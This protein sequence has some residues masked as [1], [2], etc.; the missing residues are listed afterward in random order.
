MFRSV[1]IIVTL[2]SLSAQSFGQ[3][4]TLIIKWKRIFNINPH[5]RLIFIAIIFFV[6]SNQ[7]D[8]QYTEWTGSGNW[9]NNSNWTNSYIFGQLEWKGNGNISS[10]ND[11][12]LTSQWRLYFDGGSSYFITGFPV[13]LF[14]NGGDNS[15]ILSDASVDQNLNLEVKFMD[16]GL[17]SAW[18]TTRSSGGLNFSNIVVGGNVTELRIASL[19][20]VGDITVN[21]TISASSK[22]III[23]RDESSNLQGN[24]RVNFSSAS[25]YS[26]ST[27]VAAGILTILDENALGLD[28][29][30]TI[31]ESGASLL[32][33]ASSSSTYNEVLIL[34]GVGV[35]GQGALQKM[36]S[37]SDNYF[38]SI[39]LGSDSRINIDNGSTLTFRDANF[40]FGGN[41]LYIGGSQNFSFGPNTTYSNASKTVDDGTI[42]KD[43]TGVFELRP[44]LNLTGN[45]TL[46]EGEIRQTVNDPYPNSGEII[47]RG[48]TYRSSS[49]ADRIVL[50]PT[51]VESDF[52][53]GHS[54]GGSIS[55]ISA[56]NLANGIRNIFMENNNEISGVISNG[57][58]IKS[59]L[60]SLTLSGTAANLLDPN[61]EVNEGLL[62]LNK[63]AGI[64]A[65][66]NLI[67]NTDGTVRTDQDNQWGTGTP[68][69]IQIFGNG[70]LDINNTNQNL[71]LAS[72]SATSSVI[73]GSGTLTINNTATD[74]FQGI[75]SGNGGIVKTN[76]GV[77]ILSGS[78]TYSG[79][80]NVSGGVLQISSAERISNSSDLILNGG[81]FSTG[82]GVGYNETLSALIL[83]ENSTIELGSGSH[84]LHFDASN[85]EIWNS[86][87]TLIVTGWNG[88]EE[89][90]GLEGK[91]YVG[92]D[93]SGLTSVQLANINFDGFGAGAVILNTGEVV[94]RDA[95][96]KL[97]DN[98]N[99][100]DNVNLGVPNG[101]IN[102]WTEVENLN[103]GGANGE[104][105]D[106][107]NSTLRLS[108]CVSSDNDAGNKSAAYDAS[109]IYSTTFEDA[110]GELRW[111]FNMRQSR[112]DPSNFGASGYGVAF[113]IGANESDFGSSTIDGY[114]V[115]LGESGSSDHIRLI[116]FT[117]GIP[118][119]PVPNTILSIQPNSSNLDH[120][121]SIVVTFNPCD[122]SWSLN[123]R[124][125]G[126]SAFSN[127]ISINEPGNSA[128]NNDFI[129]EPL[130]YVGAYFTHSSGCGEEAL[131]D[132]IYIPIEPSQT[133]SYTWTGGSTG[134]YQLSTNWSPQR[135]CKKNNDRLV[136]STNTSIS[137]TNVPNELIGY[138]E[139][140]NNTSLTLVDIDNSTT[141]SL[142]I[143]NSG[144][145]LNVSSGSNLILDV[146]SSATGNGVQFHLLGNTTGVI[147]GSF[148]MT[149]SQTGA[150]R[151][152]LLE[153]ESTGAI[154]VNGDIV[155]EDLT[156][157]PFGSSTAGSVIFNSGSTLEIFDGANPF[158]LASPAS[159]IEFN[160]GSTY[161][162]LDPQ[163]GLSITGRTYANFIFDAG[164]TENITFSGTNTWTVEDLRVLSG[165][166]NASPNGALEIDIS[167]DLE[168]STGASFILNPDLE[169]TIRF[170]GSSLQTIYGDGTLSFGENQ[171]LE[172]DNTTSGKAVSIEK[173]IVMNNDFRIIDGRVEGTGYDLTMNGI[174]HELY[175]ND[176]LLGEFPG[177]YNEISLIIS[178]NTSLKGSAGA[179]DFFDITVNNSK[180][181]FLE[182]SI[183]CINGT[184][185]IQDNA[186]LQINANGF[187]ESVNTNAVY[188][189]YGNNSILVY[190]TGNIYSRNV[191]WFTESGAGF[192]YNVLVM[193]GTTLNPGG[194]YTNE[195]LSLENNLEIEN[196]AFLYMDFG[197]NDMLLPLKIGGDLNL[198]GELSLSD[199]TDG[200][201]E[202]S[203]DWT[204]SG[205][206]NAQGRSV[207]FLG[208]QMQSI[209]SSTNLSFDY[210]E[211]NNS[212]VD[213]IQY[214]DDFSINVNLVFQDGILFGQ[215]T[216][217]VIFESGSNYTGASNSSHI[218]GW[219][220]K[221]GDSDFLF[222]TGGYFNDPNGSPQNYLQEIGISS[223]SGILTF[224]ARYFPETHP[225]LPGSG[226]YN[227]TSQQISGCDYWTLNRSGSPGEA[228]VTLTYGETPCNTVSD[229]N[230]LRIARWNGLAWDYPIF[231]GSDPNTP[232]EVSTISEVSNFSDFA[233]ATEGGFG[234]NVLPI[235]LLNFTAR[236]INNQ[237]VLLEWTTATETNNDFFTLER[238]VDGENFERI[239]RV[240][241]AGNATQILNYSFV[242]DD[243]FSGVSY[244]RLK[245]TD[246]DGSFQYSDLRAVEVFGDEQFD[247]KSVFRSDGGLRL[248]YT[249]DNP[250]LTLE[251]FDMT[252]KRVHSQS[253]ENE[254]N[255]IIYPNI[256]R[257]VYLLRLSNG[258]HM[259][260]EKFF[261]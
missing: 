125:D 80:T 53:V 248:I 5:L 6:I 201:L 257:G 36:D 123:I 91:I 47:F 215:G 116:H 170:N 205:S 52:T 99:R 140:S 45:I 161:R 212:S 39:S 224:D 202:I 204:Q 77:Q 55:F 152:H 62:I 85:T 82:T 245:Q 105:I 141:S 111:Y 228:I 220:R 207:R 46:V 243:P 238:S 84:S 159:V 119:N 69:F 256:A 213:G 193:S 106:L 98:F 227:G 148:I 199:Q 23:G 210:L 200:D 253:L 134:D 100:T 2:L 177:V 61:S 240:D 250:F 56:M 260:S 70:V 122:K 187:V 107:F 226:Y 258:N 42:F 208:N 103:G 216:H 40:D 130:N 3:F 66:D 20:T 247:L 22:P 184:F 93:N 96:Y 147:D 65:T 158:Q 13:E 18:I 172:I 25:L 89:S 236:N 259:A 34:N 112:S 11:L 169:S 19:N 211:I 110:A 223:L 171:I 54:G 74:E 118:S 198:F 221:I 102:A 252:G 4:N 31:V 60:G 95:N 182:R 197:S 87:S 120:Y 167:G 127:P 144:I 166:L 72:S 44:S 76:S 217:K 203:G 26:G 35:S 163:A 168:V 241:G 185:S 58:L 255:S 235:E 149:N 239:G 251:I 10:N 189:I 195:P 191:E 145:G 59:G 92:N 254:A 71:A 88:T 28:S 179:C 38:G 139:V 135:A 51:R 181:L 73:L 114:A 222:P 117:D 157:P 174:D 143:R 113:I 24:T 8:G 32:L 21:G 230:Y 79:S 108:N 104:Y 128:T 242:D 16:N 121:F 90:S 190:N 160:S 146:A 142:S 129:S 138:L 154:Q 17:R 12:N 183:Q 75:I 206:F 162:Y 180:T 48:G 9:S 155:V 249:S 244:Y 233:L 7:V 68:P 192:P 15:W 151:P 175:V 232:N 150:G 237:E 246:F 97:L 124:D 188:P 153:A 64:Q 173:D 234:L 30:P 218:D 67:I 49:T 219:V 27:T 137:V 33:N 57:S 178:E 101:Y 194:Y 229:L 196:G 136:F 37:G 165:T 43:G 164:S 29:D 63:S 225:N 41:T 78:N 261:Y 50:K 132:N 86:N 1:F 156:G 133:V 186:T 214:N 14:D 83:S 115:V 109:G 176:D 81:T 126:D 209:S 131:F 94:P 231:E